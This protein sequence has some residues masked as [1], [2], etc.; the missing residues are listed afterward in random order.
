MEILKET[1]KACEFTLTMGHHGVFFEVQATP[2][3]AQK[4]V[5]VLRDL[6]ENEDGLFTPEQIDTA[7]LVCLRKCEEHGAKIFLHEIECVDFATL[8]SQCPFI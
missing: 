7:I 2:P 3:T 4:W 1:N 5:K 6:T 8:F